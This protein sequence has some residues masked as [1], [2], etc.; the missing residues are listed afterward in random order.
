MQHQ[1]TVASFNL[2]N[3]NS[4]GT[5]YEGRD[6]TPYDAAS[7]DKKAAFVADMLNNI[8]APC[9]IGV[10][11]VFDPQAL[12]DCVARSSM[13]TAQILAPD[14]K[15]VTNPTT[16]NRTATGPN[17]GLVT[18]FPVKSIKTITEFPNEVDI[19][20][21]LGADEDMGIVVPIDIRRFERPVLKAELDVPGLPGLTVLVTH[22][23]SKRPKFLKSESESSPLAQNL[24]GLR[25]LLIRSCEAAALRSIIRAVRAERAEDG[26]RR[27]L[28]VLG[29]V[30]D[31]ISS[32]TTRMLEGSRPFARQGAADR[33]DYARRTADLMLNAM[34]LKPPA[35]GIAYSHVFEGVGTLI[36]T[37]LLS[38]DFLPIEGRQRAEITV[39]HIKVGHLRNRPL[40][41]VSLPPVNPFGNPE[42]VKL[43]DPLDDIQIDGPR[44]RKSD[45][46]SVASDHGIPSAV[47][48]IW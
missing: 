15:V 30:N 25:S 14:A 12:K 11:E 18:T 32:V 20:V 2:E 16:G 5:F 36:D 26:R 34:E 35:D 31:D 4:I 6:Q 24:G 10:Q 22:L 41:S 7:F 27:P 1:V 38:A 44:P 46:P 45:G 21:P 37:I 19:R 23:K 8:T 47:V 9:I 3:L 39:T 42:P 43:K 33:Y 29:D 40:P 13:S 17:V 28:I 48:K